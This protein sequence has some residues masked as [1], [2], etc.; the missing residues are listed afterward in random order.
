MRGAR[1]G[2]AD[3]RTRCHRPRHRHRRGSCTPAMCS[4]A[5]RPRLFLGARRVRAHDDR[6]EPEIAVPSL[7]TREVEPARPAADRETESMPTRDVQRA[8]GRDGDPGQHVLPDHTGTLG[9]GVEDRRLHGRDGGVHDQGGPFT[10][11]VAALLEERT[12]RPRL[13]ARRRGALG[14]RSACVRW[15]VATVAGDE[16]EAREEQHACDADVWH[17][18]LPGARNR[19]CARSR[20]PLKEP[21]R[22]PGS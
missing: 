5:A 15:P 2:R 3:P 22:R 8:S 19:T 9:A 1:T 16:D 18:S 14:S 13:V 7:E 4:S 21:S 20:G 12:D 11:G 17:V 10:G 6:C